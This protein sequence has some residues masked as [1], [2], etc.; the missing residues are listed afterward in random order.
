[1]KKGAV[2]VAARTE[3]YVST[4]DAASMLGVSIFSVQRWFDEG[5]LKGGRL[6]GGKRRILAASLH[7][8]MQDHGVSPRAP[9]GSDKSRILLVD[10][11]ARLLESMRDALTDTGEFVLQTASSGLDAGL[12]FAEFQPD[13]VVLDVLLDDVHGA[14]LVKRIRQ[15]PIGRQT[16]IVAISGKATPE[17]I[18]EIKTAGANA[19]LS[20]PFGSRE[21]LSAIRPAGR[22]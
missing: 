3:P 17:D 5:L 18:R 13:V 1:M 7:R 10:D 8:F 2:V 19:F 21:L 16:R 14:T 6:P 22:V 20:K 11:D 4:L 9:K 15:S 12:A